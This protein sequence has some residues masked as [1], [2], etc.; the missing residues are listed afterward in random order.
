MTGRYIGS[1][2]R[3]CNMAIYAVV[4]GEE[5]LLANGIGAQYNVTYFTTKASFTPKTAREFRFKLINS[6]ENTPPTTQFP[7]RV[8]NISLIREEENDL[9]YNFIIN[10]EDKTFRLPLLNGSE[11]LPG[12][13]YTTITFPNSDE[14]LKRNNFTYKLPQN[15][16]L[17]VTASAPNNNN[18]SSVYLRNN[19]AYIT[20][21]CSE[22][23]QGSGINCNVSGTKNQQIYSDHANMGALSYKFSPMVGNGSLYY[24]VG[25][26]IKDIS[27]IQVGKILEEL[28]KKVEIAGAAEASK[29]GYWAIDLTLGAS[30][31][32]Y[33][34]PESGWFCMSKSATAIHQYIAM[35]SYNL[36][37]L[38]KKANAVGEIQGLFFPCMKGQPVLVE[39]NMAGE[40]RWFRF[41]YDKGTEH[42]RSPN[43]IHS[44]YWS[45]SKPQIPIQ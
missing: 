33:I 19:Q 35:S 27:I 29:P 37:G 44:T 22:N 15:G 1:V 25:D 39:Y 17:S 3:A 32:V 12:N 36:I 9:P 21:Q 16:F 23:V 26:V 24:Y 28:A 6:T 8:V 30:E 7:T 34:A 14:P 38:D 45:E 41:V 4:N 42:L 18:W 31:S 2:A 40:T 11:N 43:A 20:A 13:T 10:Q 5:L